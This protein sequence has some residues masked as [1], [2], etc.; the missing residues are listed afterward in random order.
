VCKNVVNLLLLK[1]KHGFYVDVNADNHL[2]YRIT[3]VAL[4][5]DNIGYER[6]ESLGPKSFGVSNLSLKNFQATVF[7]MV[8]NVA[9]C[10]V[11][12]VDAQLGQVR[13]LQQPN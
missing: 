6:N 4:P 10:I 1:F 12:T 2:L 8:N 7:F 9:G 5:S 13:T 11:R 3:K